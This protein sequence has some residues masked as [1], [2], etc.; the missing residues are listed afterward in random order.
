MYNKVN[1]RVYR[2]GFKGTILLWNTH[3]L[4]DEQ[5]RNMAIYVKGPEDQGWWIP[6]TAMPNIQQMGK[7][8]DGKT[9]TITI[10]HDDKITANAAFQIKLVF[11][12]GETDFKEA[13]IDIEPSNTHKMYTRPERIVLPSGK[14]I[15]AENARIVDIEDSVLNRIA[16]KIK[17][18]LG[19]K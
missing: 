2:R 15:Y 6:Q 10:V 14:T 1:I 19:A 12:K 8:M 16:N 3:P 5:K 18:V 7:V 4:T 17:E 13:I 9:D 11:G